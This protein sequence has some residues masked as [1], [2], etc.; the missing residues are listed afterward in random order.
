MPLDSTPRPYG[1]LDGQIASYA[2]STGIMPKVADYSSGTLPT[3]SAVPG[4]LAI[5]AD[6]LVR[7]D[8]SSWVPANEVPSENTFRPE[9]YGA[10][11]DGVADDSAALRAMEAAVVAAGGGTIELRGKYRMPTFWANGLNITVSNVSVRGPGTI[12]MDNLDEDGVPQSTGDL[13]GHGVF[14]DVSL[15]NITIENVTVEWLTRPSARLAG[16]GFRFLG[17]PDDTGVTA[18]KDSV[19]KTWKSTRNVRLIN[20]RAYKTPQAGAIFFGCRN[21]VV[22]NF[23]T[24]DGWADRLHFNACRDAV[25]N[26]LIAIN[27]GDDGLALVNY[28][29]PTRVWQTTDE[30]TTPYHRPS[31]DEWCN[32]GFTVNN[33]R[34]RSNSGAGIGNGVR[35][36]MCKGVT[37]SGIHAESMGVN[38]VIV[39]SV[40][41]SSGYGWTHLVSRD[42]TINDVTF[43]GCASGVHFKSEGTITQD[44]ATTNGYGTVDLNEWYD[45]D[46]T[47]KSIRGRD[48]TNDF[49]LI[50]NA[51]GLRVGSVEGVYTTAK[52]FGVKS[53]GGKRISI[54]SIDVTRGLVA[55]NKTSQ[56]EAAWSSDTD[57]DDF[58]IGTITSRGST[59]NYAVEFLRLNGIE[60]RRLRIIDCDK[61]ALYFVNIANYNFPD[62]EIRNPNVGNTSSRYGILHDLT[63]A[64]RMSYKIARGS[65]SLTVVST[66]GGSS[67]TL[68][69]KDFVLIGEDRN[70]KNQTTHDCASQ[71]G[72]FAPTNFY[73][74]KMTYNGGE[75]SP[76]WRAY[77]CGGGN[78]RYDD[79]LCV[80]GTATYDPPNLTTAAPVASTTITV[81]GAAVGDLVRAE[82]DQSRTVNVD[83]DAFVSAADTVT[84]VFTKRTALTLSATPTLDDSIAAQ[85]I[86]SSFL[87][88]FVYKVGNSLASTY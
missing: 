55:I 60:V 41:K 28:F 73:I 16:D 75:A 37:I 57:R 33:I 58:S 15:E 2:T 82:I 48:C 66:G 12:L 47:I 67:S 88:A 51:N 49:L 86:A 25:V 35:V 30:G 20:C 78:F 22:E 59:S 29:H 68:R 54:E 64:G 56:D 17:Y 85:N 72:S 53:T 61:S 74:G 3:A 9:S 13:N 10:V 5:G 76:V 71:T 26:G 79:M 46:V 4:A 69:S 11:G 83:I 23:V 24:A 65:Q 52:D 87:R 34:V 31:L 6:G 19:T 1:G 63:R 21:I 62:V 77:G 39:S 44:Q 36:A 8:G 27:G 42:I 84:V 50:N 80:R 14:V 43:Q 18:T 45:F 81:P 32:S 40:M 38:A 7:S 70:T